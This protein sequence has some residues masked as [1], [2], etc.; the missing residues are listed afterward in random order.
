MS[1]IPA[2]TSEIEKAL[3]ESI[4]RFGVIVPVVLNRGEIIDGSNR[5]RIAGE[6]GITVPVI[7][8]DIEQEQADVLAVHLNTARRQLDSKTRKA[9]VASLTA[10][11]H[12]QRAIAGAVGTSKRTVEKDQV[13]TGS[14]LPE[15][16]TGLDGRT[17]KT[18]STSKA[19]PKTV[20]KL[21]EVIDTLKTI[22]KTIGS[23]DDFFA[24]PYAQR[25]KY[26]KA[27]EEAQA[28]LAILQEQ[29]V[30]LTGHLGK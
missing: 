18:R 11:G 19:S 22:P 23:D 3:R 14:Q 8:L 21:K 6:L 17:R 15:K 29:A 1:N 9:I 13:A 16:T 2:L 4:E 25:T 30:R 5:S 7:E 10:A 28:R 26:I 20:E 27:L 12:S 24:V